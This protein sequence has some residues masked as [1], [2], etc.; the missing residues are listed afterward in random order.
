MSVLVLLDLQVAFDVT[1]H[2]LM[3]FILKERIRFEHFLFSLQEFLTGTI[4]H[5][6]SIL[7]QSLLLFTVVLQMAKQGLSCYYYI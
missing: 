5:C 7:S 6:L 3:L 1:A 2:E 4:K